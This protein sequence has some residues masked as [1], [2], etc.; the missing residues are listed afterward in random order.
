[1]SVV[2]PDGAPARA[3]RLTVPFMASGLDGAVATFALDTIRWGSSVH[4]GPASLDRIA[5]SLD[6]GAI[7]PTLPEEVA[8][9]LV[10]D[11][12]E[13]CL[14]LIFG[15]PI[16]ERFRRADGG[17]VLLAYLVET[18]HYLFAAAS[19]M[20]GGPAFASHDGETVALLAEHV[21]EEAG[22]DR[23]FENALALLGCSRTTI[24]NL[25]PSPVTVEWVQLMRTVAAQGPVVAAV[26]SG[27][28][29]SSATD[30]DL[31]RGWHEMLVKNDLLSREVVD[32]ILEHVAVD[33]ELGHGTNWR[34]VIAAEAPVPSS[35]LAEALNA[36]AGVAE[37]LL[38]WFDSLDQG[39]AAGLVGVLPSVQSTTTDAPIDRF[40]D[41]LPVWPAAVLDSVAFGGSDG[42]PQHALALAFALD[43]RLIDR[44]DSE[45]LTATA[46]TLTALSVDAP[47]RLT[48]ATAEVM[49]RAW[50]R[51]IDG[52]RAWQ[53]M[54]EPGNETIVR[55]WLR[56][57]HAYLRS[58]PRHVTPA[59]RSCPDP[60][61][62]SLLL[63]HLA[64]EMDHAKLIERA[65][66]SAPGSELARTRP[67]PTTTAFIG[68]LRDLALT[69][70]RA[71]CLAL[72]YLQ[73]SFDATDPRHA[74]FYEAV[75]RQARKAGRFA[76]AMREH[77]DIDQSL[78][79]ADDSRK[80]LTAL[81]ERHP[82]T[83]EDVGRAAYVA[84]LAWSFLDGIRWHYVAGTPAEA[85]RVGWTAGPTG[86]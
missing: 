17:D 80:L 63:E 61:I 84:Q 22:H 67:L 41:G 79:H 70:W 45:P 14:D 32:A 33:D 4:P 15:H 31:V 53:A 21:V 60:V 34:H 77:D 8:A 73:W 30:R 12:I 68:Y 58:S 78:G 52:H 65:F 75:A 50:M 37:M 72:A 24:A 1:M 82:I 54:M 35:V 7:A 55:G 10:D 83:H 42:L 66:A 62:R 26:C 43:R 47:A 36:V 18:R 16:W 19:R 59:I 29:E 48:V 44:D 81:I 85:Q 2:A 56:E 28:L 51:T 71:Y 76:S 9:E 39:A 3:L 20:A 5:A 40:H 27:L 25:R 86:H 74:A 13:V 11:Q 69:D 46:G 38:R 6:L 49:L 23:F 57:N 64:E